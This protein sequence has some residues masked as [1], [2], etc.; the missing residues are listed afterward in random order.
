MENP[1]YRHC[2]KGQRLCTC[3]MLKHFIGLYQESL[4]NKEKKIKIKF[5]YKDDLDHCHT[6]NTHLDIA[7]FLIYP[8]EKID[9]LIGDGSI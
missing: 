4:K 3:C 6:N 9:Y 5:S 7:D 1:C 2:G 8:K